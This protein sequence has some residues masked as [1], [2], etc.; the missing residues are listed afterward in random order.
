[1]IICST[2]AVVNADSSGFAVVLMSHSRFAVGPDWKKSS[3]FFPIF[4]LPTFC[5][6]FKDNVTGFVNNIS[7]YGCFNQSY[8][9][10]TSKKQCCL[11]LSAHQGSGGVLF[12]RH[13]VVAVW[14]ERGPL[15]LLVL[16]Y[17][18]Y[19]TS[20]LP[21]KSGSEVAFIAA[22]LEFPTRPC[23]I[24]THSSG[25]EAVFF[26]CAYVYVSAC[27]QLRVS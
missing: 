9:H 8:Q 5:C 2:L 10:V 18:C 7:T 3:C 6:S 26:V 14:P 21:S 20:N 27:G 19:L 24:L 15:S 23:V 17:D 1:M 22:W 12:Y 16:V 11:L 25:E 4:L 13:C